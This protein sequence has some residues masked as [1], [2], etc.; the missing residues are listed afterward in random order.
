MHQDLGQE[1]WLSVKQREGE[2]L[3]G[4]TFSC[5]E[6]LQSQKVGKIAN[7]SKRNSNF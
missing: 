2:M 4:A 7:S 6:T 1:V 5:D 3:T